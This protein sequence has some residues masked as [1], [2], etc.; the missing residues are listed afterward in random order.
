MYSCL[1]SMRD[2][3]SNY[4]PSFQLA[5]ILYSYFLNIFESTYFSYDKLHWVLRTF[6]LNFPSLFTLF[7]NSFSSFL[8]SHKTVFVFAC[9]LFSCHIPIHT[10]SWAWQPPWKPPYTPQIQC[11]Y[12]W[13]HLIAFNYIYIYISTTMCGKKKVLKKKSEYT[14]H[15]LL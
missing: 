11:Q 13:M 8:D 15:P 4:W 7:N 12:K 6:F 5:L 3:L 9:F 1:S 2:E 14:H 10:G